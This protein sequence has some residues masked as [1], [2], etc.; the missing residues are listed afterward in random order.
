MANAAEC[1]HTGLVPWLPAE[2]VSRCRPWLRAPQMFCLGLCL[3]SS[4]Q[5]RGDAKRNDLCSSPRPARLI[6][7][8][9]F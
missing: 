8:A 2:Q 5:A 3:C 7:E 9:A 4:D 6:Q 1:H